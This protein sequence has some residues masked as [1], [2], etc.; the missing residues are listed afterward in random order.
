MKPHYFVLA[1]IIVLLLIGVV[2]ATTYTSQYPLA[3]NDTYVKSTSELAANYHIY[4]AT[5]PTKSLI[6]DA[7][8]NAWIAATE[9]NQRIHVDLGSAKVIKRIYYEN[10]HQAGG[11]TDRGSNAVT[12]WGTNSSTAF[13]EL[14]YSIDTDWTQ[15]TLASGNLTQH[16]ALDQ[17]DPQYILVTNDAPCQYYALKVAS[18]FGG[19]YIGI[20]RIVLQTED[21][22]APVGNFSIS[23]TTGTAPLIAAFT[24]TSTNTPTGWNWSFTNVTGDNIQVWFSTSQN[25]TKTFTLAGNYSIQLN[26]TNAGG[27]NTTPANTK[28]VNVSSGATTPIVLWT[29]NSQTIVFPGRLIGNDSSLNTPTA[30]CWS[31]GDGSAVQ[32]TKNV[33]YQY[34]KRG[35]WNASLNASNAAGYNQSYKLIRIL[36]FA[37][38]AGPS[39]PLPGVPWREQ[40]SMEY[41]TYSVSRELSP[42]E[43]RMTDCKLIGLCEV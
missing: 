42:A 29:V 23:N 18:N 28:W 22:A 11:Y 13:A 2:Q 20:R 6:G 38:G 4:Y 32:T 40:V 17:A 12:F 10:H 25:P 9:S 27:A 26:V 16:V 24:D 37:Q 14:T 19:T 30:W 35:V 21:P 5:D 3:H 34:V 41:G 15:M 33:T 7:D 43:R 39:A 8:G 1:G 31:F 36:G